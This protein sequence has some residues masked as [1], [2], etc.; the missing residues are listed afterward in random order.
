LFI[1]L[2]LSDNIYIDKHTDIFYPICDLSYELNLNFGY[3]ADDNDIIIY[4][5]IKYAKF[6]YLVYNLIS[7]INNSG[8]KQ[9]SNINKLNK[10]FNINNYTCW[11]T[12]DNDFNYDNILGTHTLSPDIILNN[13]TYKKSTQIGCII[14][15]IVNI[16]KHNINS[17]IDECSNKIILHQ[18][19]VSNFMNIDDKIITRLIDIIKTND[20][21]EYIK[22][23]TG[24]AYTHINL[25]NQYNL[26][27][28]SLEIENIIKK[29][30]IINITN[31]NILFIDISHSEQNNIIINNYVTGQFKTLYNIYLYLLQTK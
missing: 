23:Y 7:K 27:N 28:C 4:D 22:L 15:K 24:N 2:I 11:L 6:I 21:P 26:I 30:N 10:F 1:K 12:F 25:Y 19:T 31:S 3:I 16:I 14:Q 29:Q 20:K 5:N 18:K 8:H 13:I 17:L 9:L